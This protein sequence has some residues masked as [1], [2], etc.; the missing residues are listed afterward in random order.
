MPRLTLLRALALLVAAVFV[1]RTGWLQALLLSPVTL[2]RGAWGLLFS[3][4]PDDSDSIRAAMCNITTDY[5]KV[6][7]G[8]A[9]P[10][11]GPVNALIMLAR[12]NA[13][14]NAPLTTL[15]PPW[16]QTCMLLQFC[17]CR[18]LPRR[19]CAIGQILRIMFPV[20]HPADGGA[21]GG[22]SAQPGHRPAG[23]GALPNLPRPPARQ[24]Q[25][26]SAV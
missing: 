8:L 16:Q 25:R 23:R 5:K 6:A 9:W 19:Y 13:P 11:V 12:L 10:F 1:W 17:F 4:A 14:T 7:G 2:L 3:Q 15:V 24:V 21:G 20:C 22:L 26:S 18:A